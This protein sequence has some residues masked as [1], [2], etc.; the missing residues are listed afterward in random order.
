MKIKREKTVCTAI[1]VKQACVVLGVARITNVVENVGVDDRIVPVVNGAR[2]LS[3]WLLGYWL[4]VGPVA[5]TQNVT[6]MTVH[7]LMELTR[8]QKPLL[9]NRMVY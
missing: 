9:R 8:Y 4:A 3:P 1:P 5:R 2:L 7:I 6:W